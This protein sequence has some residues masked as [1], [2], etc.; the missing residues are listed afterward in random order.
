MKRI[1][2]LLLPCLALCHL[3]GQMSRNIEL[4]YNWTDTTNIIEINAP[5]AITH[6][7]YNEVWG[8]AQNGHE[9]AVI[10]STM[11][12]HFFDVTD[13]AHLVYVDFVPGRAQ[14]NII[15]RDFKNYRHYL[16]AVCDEGNSSLQVVDLQYLPDSVHVVYDDDSLVVRAH[17]LFID[18]A[19]Q[20]LYVFGPR[21][22][23]FSPGVPVGYPALVLS[24]ADPVNPQFLSTF[25]HN[26]ITYVHDGYVY[27]DTAIFNCGYDGL[28]YGYFGNTSSPV[29]IDA[30]P[31]YEDQ[32]YNHSG[33][34]TPDKTHYIM[35][36]ETHG[37]RMKMLDMQQGPNQLSTCNLIGSYV[38]QYSIA[39]NQ[40]I[41]G[42]YL[43]VSYY[44]D[45]LRVFDITDPCSIRQVAWYDT[46]PGDA[47]NGCYAGA[48]GTYP[49]LPSGKVLVSDIETGLYVFRPQTE[50]FGIEDAYTFEFDI[51]PNPAEELVQLNHAY[52]SIRI[53]DMNGQLVKTYMNVQT[54]PVSELADGLYMLGVEENGRWAYKKLI[55]Q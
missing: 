8:Y 34:L 36:D 40:L 27:N 17:N 20:K 28:Y 38:S 4:I 51:Y 13:S 33:W 25:N 39:H 10:G 35:S 44:Y 46:Y 19:M 14:G 37:M 30:L 11:G 23:Y 47:I 9:Y 7:R 43:Y 55:K 5:P 49:L 3:P 15:H 48:W 31:F 1:Y 18:T 22:D 21:T 16:Y 6:F 52:T 24:I 54:F 41:R 29:E 12:L 53:V 2:T 32:G 42:N 50:F 45:G 26:I